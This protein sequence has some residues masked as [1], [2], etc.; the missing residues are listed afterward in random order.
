MRWRSWSAGCIGVC[1]TNTR[2][3]SLFL[4]SATVLMSLLGC[5]DEPIIPLSSA[6]CEGPAWSFKRDLGFTQWTD[7]GGHA[8]VSGDRVLV[9]WQ[10]RQENQGEHDEAKFLM[11]DADTGKP[12]SD[13]RVL[14]GGAFIGDVFVLGGGADNG[15]DGDF[16]VFVTQNQRSTVFHIDSAGVTT[17]TGTTFPSWSQRGAAV[18][19]NGVVV[20]GNAE[21]LRLDRRGRLLE[22]IITSDWAGSCDSVVVTPGDRLLAWCFDSIEERRFLLAVN[23]DGTDPVRTELSEFDNWTARLAATDDGVYLAFADGHDLVASFRNFDGAELTPPVEL[24]RQKRGEIV[25]ATGCGATCKGT[26]LAAQGD[27]A[28]FS[29]VSWSADDEGRFDWAKHAEVYH[30]TVEGG[31]VVASDRGLRTV[32]TTLTMSSSNS[33]PVSTWSDFGLHIPIVDGWPPPV[34]HVERGCVLQPSEKASE[35]DG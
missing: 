25:G 31:V 7:I 11:L 23:D 19:S 24:P 5:D 22:R 21:L 27:A 4:P 32:E 26:A 28:L 12:I 30:L 15:E 34:L 33:S 35:I 13:A 10:E 3:R 6:V 18:T 2:R 17:R 20:L 16:L 1:M 14:A 29:V 8:A 9:V